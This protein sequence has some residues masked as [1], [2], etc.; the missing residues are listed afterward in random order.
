MGS[1]VTTALIVGLFSLTYMINLPFGYLRGKAKKFSCA[2]F[3]YIH[4]PIP[5]VII[6]RLSSHLDYRYIPLF[7]LAAIIGQY[8][9]GKLNF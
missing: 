6:T 3:L 7:L 2:W 5:F 8:S 4:M 9:G 1:P